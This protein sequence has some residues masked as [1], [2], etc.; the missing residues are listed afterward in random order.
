MRIKIKATDL[1]LTPSIKQYVEKKMKSMGKILKSFEK[2]G[3]VYIYFEIARTTRHHKS[4][5]IFYAEANVDL[6]GENV[7]AEQRDEDI[8]AAI[9]KV[10]DILKREIKELKERQISSRENK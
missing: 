6:L 9:D 8:R 1:E 4:G 2:E 3:E 7:R 10:K 5:N